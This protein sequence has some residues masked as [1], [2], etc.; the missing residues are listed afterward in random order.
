LIE[1]GIDIRKLDQEEKITTLLNNRQNL[2]TLADLNN[3]SSYI[4]LRIGEFLSLDLITGTNILS[5]VFKGIMNTPL[6]L[7]NLPL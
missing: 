1:S 7:L 4:L 6:A 3:L 2:E 5:K